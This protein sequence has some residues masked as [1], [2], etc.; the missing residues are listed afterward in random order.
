MAAELKL[1]AN[2][3]P[4]GFVQLDSLSSVTALSSPGKGRA[5]LI[6]ADGDIRWRDDGED[7]SA[8]VGMLL[9]DGQQVFYPG[10]LNR[11]KFIEV[12]PSAK[13]NI[14]F[15]ATSAKVIPGVHWQSSIWS[16]FLPLDLDNTGGPPTATTFGSHPSNGQKHASAVLAPNGFIYSPPYNNSTSII[17]ID[18]STDTATTFGG[19]Y[20]TGFFKWG[21]G[22]LAPNGMLYF[23]PTASNG[24]NPG[25]RGILKIDPETDT[26]TEIGQG[27]ILGAGTNS[28]WGAACVGHDGMVYGIPAGSL[29]RQILRINPLN[30]SYSILGSYSPTVST[31]SHVGGCIA[32]NGMIYAVPSSGT[33]GVWKINPT[34]GLITPFGGPFAS[35]I[36]WNSPGLAPS[37]KI[38]CAPMNHTSIL[39]IDPETDTITQFGAFPTGQNQWMA[40][41]LASNGKFYC[42]PRMDTNVL[43]IDPRTDT[44]T[45]F[46]A[47]GAGGNKWGSGV[48]ALNGNI[49]CPPWDSTSYLK[50][51]PNNNG[52]FNPEFVLSRYLNR[53]P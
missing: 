11:L 41:V 15:F 2:W 36:K 21:G 45:T 51:S 37:G 39:K 5:A 6:Q 24:L 32:N 43:E 9:L 20:P 17:K 8:S 33:D 34:T 12:A 47:L 46:G 30:D 29:R 1:E 19:P 4:S 38:Y 42:M 50:V 53:C 7:P 23:V 10:D 3:T 18:P 35:N 16:D 40:T 14:T 44:T 25:G 28:G 13:A 26:I 27:Q 31:I 49:Y 48:L 52:L 22:C